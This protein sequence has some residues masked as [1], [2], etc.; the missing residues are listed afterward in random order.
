[1]DMKRFLAAGIGLGWL[2]L[3]PGSWGS[4]LPAGVFAGMGLAGCRLAIIG[5]VLVVLVL[6]GAI[7][8][9]ALSGHTIALTGKKDPGEVVL[10][11]VAGQALCLLASLSCLANG[12]VLTIKKVLYIAVAGFLCFR[13]FDTLKPWPCRQLEGLP[14]GWGILADDM[15]AGVY[16]AIGL[17]VA[18]YWY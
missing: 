14:A 8:C 13:F 7:G 3:A 18:I 11:E 4:L 5:L 16:A 2:P 1:M 6:L 9:L 12:P 17:L 10:D 15:A